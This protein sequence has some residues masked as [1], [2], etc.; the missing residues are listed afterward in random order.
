[1]ENE[2]ATQQPLIEV[3]KPDRHLFS[4]VFGILWKFLLHYFLPVI[5][6][7]PV[8][9]GAEKLAELLGFHGSHAQFLRMVMLGV[10]ALIVFTMAG[11]SRK[12]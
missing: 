1:M 8:L 9:M 10:Y 6:V 2:N 11:R 5:A 3:A 4:K 12:K 7:G